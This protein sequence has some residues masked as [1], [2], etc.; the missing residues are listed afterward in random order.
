MAREASGS[1]APRRLSTI[2]SQLAHAV[3]ALQP[4]NGGHQLPRL[5]QDRLEWDNK[6]RRRHFIC[7]IKFKLTDIKFATLA[8]IAGDVHTHIGA[9]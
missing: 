7:K 4:P 2:H 3:S 8:H 1:T 5:S 9:V 6:R